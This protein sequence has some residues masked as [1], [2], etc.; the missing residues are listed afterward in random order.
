MK[1]LHDLKIW[2]RLV[3]MIWMMLFVTWAIL[4]FWTA[5][6]Q[7]EFAIE[8]ARDFSK[9]VHKMTMASLT[10]MMITGTVA[11]RAVFLDQ[12]R[13]SDDIKELRVIRSDA[14]AKQFGAGSSDEQKMDAVENQVMQS[15]KPYFQ[16][17]QDATGS[18]LRAIIPALAQ[19]NYLGKNCLLCHIVPEGTVLGAVSMQISLNKASVAVRDLTLSIV[20]VAIGLSIPLILFIYLFVKRVVTRPLESM[21]NGLRDIA[22]GEGDLTRRLVVQSN[23]EIGEASMVSNQM[24]DKFREMIQHVRESADQVFTAAGQLSSGAKQVAHGTMLQGE[25]S[26]LTSV[27]VNE[28]ASRVGAIAKS[29]ELVQSHSE[30][31]KE[32]ATEANESLAVLLGEICMVESGR[33]RK[34]FIHAVIV[35]AMAPVL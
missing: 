10:G 19:Q 27:A 18:S 11:Q 30:E 22:Q 6:E 8:Q 4:I 28:M 24:M 34:T 12:I 2:V 17:Q 31:S 1:K 9:S 5:H 3:A 7:N 14:V 13:Q 16:V 15:G 20:F 33:S 32:R 23:D 25:K 35:V 29:T 21:T 26:A